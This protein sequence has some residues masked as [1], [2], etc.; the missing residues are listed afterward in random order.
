[1]YQDWNNS[2][3]RNPSPLRARQGLQ[4]QKE[5]EYTPPDYPE[6]PQYQAPKSLDTRKV[7]KAGVEAGLTTDEFS[8]VLNQIGVVNQAEQAEALQ[9]FSM[10]MADY[11]DQFG[12]MELERNE[13]QD[14]KTDIEEKRRY[15]L[16]LAKEADAEAREIGQ[17][18]QTEARKAFEFDQGVRLGKRAEDRKVFEAEQAAKA[19]LVPKWAGSQAESLFD[20]ETKE[21]VA[22]I[23]AGGKG[24]GGRSN[25]GTFTT[26]QQRVKL[27]KQVNEGYTGSLGIGDK[28]TPLGKANFRATYF[29]DNFTAVEGKGKKA[30]QFM[31]LDQGTGQMYDQYLNPWTPAKGKGAAKSPGGLAP[32]TTT[33]PKLTKVGKTT[34]GIKA[35]LGLKEKK[36]STKRGMKLF[37][38][39]NDKDNVPFVDTKSLKTAGMAIVKAGITASNYADAA[40]AYL[41][42]TKNKVEDTAINAIVAAAKAAAKSQ[43]EARKEGLDF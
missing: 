10:V 24:A 13:K 7:L 27:N 1:M 42:K 41:I 18:E 14:F 30:G 8:S 37:N 34:E 2:N 43:K 15:G 38:P 11:Q 6:R 21:G 26:P 19:G 40:R 33:E 28:G 9:S 17:F 25:S 3:N 4:E 35:S 12:R 31:Y 39:A 22:R 16:G 29:G 36:G 32:E 23:K 5:P 20:R